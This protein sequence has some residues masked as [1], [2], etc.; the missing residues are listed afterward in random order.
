MSVSGKVFDE[1]P[2]T[3]IKKTPLETKLASLK[4]GFN[5]GLIEY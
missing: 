1:I 5:A 3:H 2:G 4:L